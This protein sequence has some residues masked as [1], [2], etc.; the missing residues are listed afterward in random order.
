MQENRSFDHYFGTLPNA[1]GFSDPNAITLSSGHKVW[2][3]P[4]TLN[5]DGYLLPFHADTTT[6]TA[7]ALPSTSHAWNVQHESWDGGL[8]DGFVSS[9]AF[10]GADVGPFTMSYLDRTDIP[11]H[12][13]LAENFT[14]RD[15]YHCSLLG[16]TWPNRLY[17]MS[18]W[19]VGLRGRRGLQLGRRD[20]DQDRP[21]HRLDRG[22]GAADVDR[23]QPG[24]LPGVGG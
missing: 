4:D 13:A 8:M 5:P 17:L 20:L 7:Q 9:H 19:V 1:R 11:F 23:R 2:Y 6:T 18:A 14:I 16:P 24:R 22:A 10:Q 15:G 21:G 3:Q 12:Y